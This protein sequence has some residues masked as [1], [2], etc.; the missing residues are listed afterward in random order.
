MI[1]LNLRNM[2]VNVKFVVFLADS[3]DLFVIS[4]VFDM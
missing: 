4:I 3:C 2:S 1:W